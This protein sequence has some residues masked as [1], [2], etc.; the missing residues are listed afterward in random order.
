MG[1]PAVSVVQYGPFFAEEEAWHV[2]DYG[3]G[4]LRNAVYLTDR[5][6]RVYAADLPAHLEKLAGR[7]ELSRLE[8][9][10][11]TDELPHAGL[12]VDLV[13]ST[14]VFN[15]LRSREERNLYLANAAANLR[16]GG[17]FLME[18]AC[19][20]NGLPCG[21]ECPRHFR[22]DCCAKALTH[23][24]LD[25]FL[26]PYGFRRVRHEYRNWAVSAVYV[27]DPAGRREGRGHEAA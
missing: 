26:E 21:S 12:N 2:L 24:E 19:P 25:A 23:E 14:Y 18:V 16:P 27:L 15:I 6:F 3:T 11:S 10:L 13:I 20:R 4:M 8:G 9:V 5:G 1:T 22:D 17:Y 7:E